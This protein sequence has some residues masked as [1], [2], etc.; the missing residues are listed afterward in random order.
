MCT[1]GRTLMFTYMQSMKR[2]WNNPS[3][4]I[5][6][7][8]NIYSSFQAFGNEFLEWLW[9]SSAFLQ[10]CMRKL[11]YFQRKTVGPAFCLA[12]IWLC[13][14]LR[15]TNKCT[16]ARQ[17]ALSGPLLRPLSLYVT[18][19]SGDQKYPSSPAAIRVIKLI[20]I[21]VLLPAEMY[22]RIKGKIVSA[23]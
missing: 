10:M 16:G 17:K 18:Y 7:G 6:L 20:K 4:Q 5:I 9:S 22:C 11:D 8:W 14:F 19:H 23:L 15:R 12:S 2:Y 13:V 1:L 21:N 3:L